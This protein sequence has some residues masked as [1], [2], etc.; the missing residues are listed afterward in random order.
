MKKTQL[1]NYA[2]LITSVG[3][4]I[5]KGQEVDVIASCDQV[6]L[7]R[8]ITKE[9]YRLKAKRVNVRFI[10]DVI[11]KTHYQKQS[12][13]TLNEFTPLMKAKLEREKEVLPCM[14]Y[15][16][17]S[18]P[19][20]FKG[21]NTEKINKSRQALYP[22][23]KPYLDYIENR[24]QWCIVA[25]PSYAWAKKVFPNESKRDAYKKLEQGIIEC[26]RLDAEDP[27]AAWQKHIEKLNAQAKVMNDYHFDSLTYT[28]SNKTNFTIGLHPKHVW[29]SARE[30]TLQGVEFSANM[31]TEEVFTMPDKYRA[32]GIVYATKPLSY[33]GNLI[34]DFSIEFKDGKAVKVQAR[35]G[36]KY[37]EEMIKMDEAAAYLGEVALVPFDSPI[38][39][40]DYLFYNTLFDENAC[41]HLALGMAFRNNIA[42]FEEMSDEDFKQENYN[43]S[44]NHVDFMIGSH[45]LKIVGHRENQED[46]VVF[47]NGV[48]AI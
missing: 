12:Q 37:L 16:E 40:R 46:V 48:W 34:E 22:H 11:S 2:K 36:Q 13:A 31:P 4:N 27:T 45:D 17:D 33:Q 8:L 6:E 28:S 26:T 19:D 3:V 23:R 47:E 42:G 21:I 20:A 29:L 18:D 24:E 1:K 25:M 32:E 44:M 15:I 41:C 5:Q 38:N 39:Q 35:V 30:K 14:I 7:A 10:D 43:D 9:A